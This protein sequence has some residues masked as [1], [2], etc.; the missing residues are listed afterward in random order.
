MQNP[1]KLVGQQSS[2]NK[3]TVVLLAVLA[4]ILA[5]VVSLQFDLPV[6]LDVYRWAGPFFL[7]RGWLIAK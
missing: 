3:E 2:A 4:T 1:Q 7:A 5:W 6:P